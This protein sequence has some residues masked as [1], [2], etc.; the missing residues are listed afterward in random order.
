MPLPILSTDARFAERALQ[1]AA[2]YG[3]VASDL[4][5]ESGCVLQLGESGLALLTLG[6]NMPGPVLVDFVAG[7]AD[8]RRK[9]GGG[10]GQG[11]A[12]ACAL[13]G[14]ATPYVLDATAGLG[15]DAFVLAG[16]G[17]RVD[18]LERSPIA[19]ALLEDGMQRA[20]QAPDVAPVIERMRLHYGSALQALGNWVGERPEVIY[21]DPMFPEK[22]KSALSKKDMQAFQLVVGADLDADALLAPA[23]A[24]ALARVAVKR[25]RHAPW[26]AGQKPNFSL[27][28]DSV[29]FDIYLPLP[30]VPLA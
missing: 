14:G 5:P 12:K 13:K 26:L 10:R 4:M 18:M 11:V 21:L 24:L 20:L 16:L 19:A 2:H 22:A 7:A 30:A 9:H 27:D 15:R 1:L 25:P 28:G 23:R 17:C 3:F 6:R 29:R 8:W